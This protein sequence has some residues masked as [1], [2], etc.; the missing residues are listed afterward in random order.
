MHFH[1]NPTI[2]CYYFLLWIIFYI[3]MW[4]YS[5]P[6]AIG[7]SSGTFLSYDHIV[8]TWSTSLGGDLYISYLIITL[9]TNV[10]IKLISTQTLTISP[11]KWIISIDLSSISYLTWNSLIKE[12]DYY[13]TLREFWN[14]YLH[15][16][17]DHLFN[18]WKRKRPLSLHK[19]IVIH[20]HPWK[21]M[22]IV[23]L[24]GKNH[25]LIIL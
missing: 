18:T 10:L 14:S 17:L 22:L 13:T 20:Y 1:I 3:D 2:Q 23:L 11:I 21:G 24:K 6:I 19:K 16:N 4:S 12:I 8:C 15:Y 7:V 5:I 9:E 25:H